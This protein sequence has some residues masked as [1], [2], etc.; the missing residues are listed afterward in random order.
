MA[1]TKNISLFNPKTEKDYRLEFNRSTVKQME[2]QGFDVTAIANAS[3]SAGE[4]LIAGAF[5]ANH[6]GLSRAERKGLIEDIKNAPGLL[7]KLAEMYSDTVLEL[8]GTEGDESKNVTW[9]ASF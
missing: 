7:E 4:D 1:N 2:Q 5:L 6:R 8:Y 3:V 9:E